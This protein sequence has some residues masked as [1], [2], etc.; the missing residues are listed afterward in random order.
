MDDVAT[1]TS[2]ID[3]M[4]IPKQGYNIDQQTDFELMLGQ[5]KTTIG[6]SGQGYTATDPQK[7]LFF[8]SDGV[9]DSYKPTGCLKTT[10]SGRCQAPIDFGICTKIKAAGVRIAVLHHLPAD[11]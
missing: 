1:K 6:T 5:L 3:L 4:S 9:N 8:V 7:V 11:Q 2:T 10:T